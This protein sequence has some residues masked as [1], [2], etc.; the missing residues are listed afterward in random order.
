MPNKNLSNKC[1]GDVDVCTLHPSL[2]LKPDSS[3][4][5]VVF[6]MNLMKVDAAR[7]VDEQNCCIGFVTY[8]DVIDH[9]YDEK[10]GEGDVCVCDV[11]RQPNMSVFLDDPVEQALITMNLHNVDC[12]PVVNFDTQKFSDLICREDVETCFQ[13]YSPS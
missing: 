9:V 8:D 1:V 6:V 10:Q 13:I 3:L 2:S 4:P 12:L 7:I 11:M 5:F